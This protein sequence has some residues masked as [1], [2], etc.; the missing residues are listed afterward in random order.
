MSLD[1][2][3]VG[4]QLKEASVS[5]I[6]ESRAKR[7]KRWERGVSV[8]CIRK[9]NLIDGWESQVLELE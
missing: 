8:Y 6:R 4:L 2:E 3:Y 1:Q 5:M 7:Q 9:K